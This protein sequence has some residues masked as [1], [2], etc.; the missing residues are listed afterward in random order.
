MYTSVIILAAGQG[1]RMNAHKNKQF[2]KVF[3]KA[4]LLYTLEAFQKVDEIDEIIFVVNKKENNEI[5]RNIVD[6][7]L[8]K[9]GIN[10]KLVV[11]GKERYDS[12][13]NGLK[14]LNGQCRYVLVHDGARPLVSKEEIISVLDGLN[15]SKACVL[16][17]KA[18]N[19]FKLVNKSG[20]VENT[21]SRERL[22]SIL[23]P[24]GFHKSVIKEAY[25]RGIKNAAGITDD[26]MMVEQYTDYMVKIIEGTYENIKITTPEDLLLMEG[27]LRKKQ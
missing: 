16:G 4:I 5:K 18:K 20:Y 15:E 2:L 21:L 22:Y 11:G 23:T 13:Y 26:G 24:Q 8:E 19:T 27:F 6:P 12:V 9:S 3:G 17:V 1:K 7:F 25:D 10:L 14:V